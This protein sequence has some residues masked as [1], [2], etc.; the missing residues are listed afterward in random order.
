MG[1]KLRVGQPRVGS[2][3]GFGGPGG[4]SGGPGGGFFQV[5]S[6]TALPLPLLLSRSHR[7]D[8]Q[9]HHQEPPKPHQNPLGVLPTRGLV[10]TKW[11]SLGDVSPRSHPLRQSALP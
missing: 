2:G 5:V 7:Q 11:V 1:T 4:D 8:H 6:V 10:P 3:S 9:N